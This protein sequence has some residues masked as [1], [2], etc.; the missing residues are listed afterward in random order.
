M[1]MF[2]DYYILSWVIFC[3]I[4]TTTVSE[5]Y[6]GEINNS[7]N[8]G[9][10]PEERRRIQLHQHQQQQQNPNVPSKNDRN[11]ESGNTLEILRAVA[12]EGRLGLAV[13]EVGELL[14]SP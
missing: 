13:R 14:I 7:K 5:Q 4:T 11:K 3:G 12:P 2:Y 8:I 10:T 1:R 9:G 6:Y